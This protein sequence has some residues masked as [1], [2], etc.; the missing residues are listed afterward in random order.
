MT[1][2][3]EAA[4]ELELNDGATLYV[5]TDQSLHTTAYSNSVFVILEES[6]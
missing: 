1:C 2:L 6:S 5:V 3:R 4:Q